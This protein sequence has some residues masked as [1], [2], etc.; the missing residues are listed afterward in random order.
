MLRAYPRRECVHTSLAFLT[1]SVVAA[2]VPVVDLGVLPGAGRHRRWPSA[3]LLIE[4]VVR[5]I[6]PA[7]CARLGVIDAG[8]APV[9][10][11]WASAVFRARGE[12][13]DPG[14]GRG[15]ELGDS[16]SSGRWRSALSSVDWWAML[17]TLG[18]D[19]CRSW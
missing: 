9:V 16:W 4:R 14:R 17:A 5:P 13:G 19:R 1:W 10:R 6:E 2:I 18:L 15:D 8:Y 7:I 3:L 11:G 12:P